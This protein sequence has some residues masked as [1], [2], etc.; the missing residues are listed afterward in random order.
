MGLELININEVNQLSACRLAEL[1]SVTAP[2]NKIERFLKRTKKIL[3]VG[4]ALCLFKHEPYAWSYCMD[5]FKSFALNSICAE[6]LFKT[7]TPP[8]LTYQHQEYLSYHACVETHIQSHQRMIAFPLICSRQEECIGQL[9]FLDHQTAPF[10][11][12][13]IQEV[14][15]LADDFIEYIELKTE[16]LQ[17]K[18]SCE[19]L[20]LLNHSKTKFFQVIAHD[21]RAPFHGLMGF[22]EVLAEELH[23][24][25]AEST[26]SIATYLNDTA[27]SSYQL[28]ENL[29]DWAMAEGGRFEYHPIHLNLKQ[30]S[31]NIVN[32]LKSLALNKNI[33]LIDETPEHLSVFADI[34]MLTSTLQN[35]VS[36]AL[37]FTP[38]DGSGRVVI[39]AEQKGTLVY[40][41]VKD[42]GLGMNNIQIKNIFEP[43]IAT[44]LKGTAGEKGTGL[45]LVLC[46]RFIEM[47]HGHIFVNSQEGK[48]TTFTVELPTSELQS[49]PFIC[50]QKTA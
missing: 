26:Q 23:T 36:N 16:S 39:S 37:K 47:N 35:L 30:V 14:H 25:D 6:E 40:L 17:L 49:T 11:E 2:N 3:N 5:G 18:K 27:K 33:E 4:R 32:I 13:D 44:S 42:T 8:I 1:L 29:L 46:K 21:L 41:Y 50:E 20:S 31:Q 24:L 15:L 10:L 12:D 19:E 38:K 28:L 34:N 22:S 7:I 48:G 43:K 9:I 45:G